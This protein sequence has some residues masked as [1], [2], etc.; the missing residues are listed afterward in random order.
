MFTSSGN[1]LEFPHR[2]CPAARTSETVQICAQVHHH[3]FL[4]TSIYAVVVA[5]PDPIVDKVNLVL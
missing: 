4:F 5:G 1:S 3:V 2:T